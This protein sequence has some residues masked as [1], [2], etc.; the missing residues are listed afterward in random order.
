[1]VNINHIVTK[2]CTWKNP[3]QHEFFS[4]YLKHSEHMNYSLTF[5]TE[6]LY[7]FPAQ[8]QLSNGKYESIHA[9]RAGLHFI[10]FPLG[11]CDH[12]IVSL[13][14]SNWLWSPQLNGKRLLLLHG[15]VAYLPTL[16]QTSIFNGAPRNHPC[17]SQAR[18]TSP[19]N[20]QTLAQAASSSPPMRSINAASALLQLFTDH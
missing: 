18:P 17:L 10:G 7:I 6:V 3:R 14:L 15:G 13:S 4:N 8:L 16:Q 5:A 12:S 9:V 2:F 20:K 19:S 1:M 11:C